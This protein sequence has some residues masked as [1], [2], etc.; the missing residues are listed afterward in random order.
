MKKPR[1]VILTIAIALVAL[2]AWPA[3]A[4]AEGTEL[5]SVSSDETQSDNASAEPSLSADGSCVAFSSTATNLW[6]GDERGEWYD[7]DNPPDGVVDTFQPY[8]QVYVRDLEAGTTQLVSVNGDGSEAGDHSSYMPSVNAD[9][10]MVAFA[11]YSTNLIDGVG[12][13]VY[14]NIFV[15]DL[16]NGITQLVSETHG[17]GPV[18]GECMYPSISADGSA[19]A[20]IS[21]ATNLLEG[22]TNGCS[23]VFVRYLTG[24]LAGTT[25]LASVAWGGGPSEGLD[26]GYGVLGSYDPS[27]DADGSVVAFAS[28]ATNLLAEEDTDESSDV[29]VRDL[30]AGTTQPVSVVGGGVGADSWSASPS[31]NADGSVVAFVS[32]ANEPLSLGVFALGEPVDPVAGPD[33]FVRDLV[34]GTTELVSVPSGGV[35][36]D[37]VNQDPSI[38][39]DGSIVAFWSVYETHDVAGAL[40]FAGTVVPVELPNVFVRDRDRGTTTLLSVGWDGSASNGASFGPSVSADGSLVAFA[41]DATN[42]VFGDA[43]DTWDVFLARYA[44]PKSGY[45]NRYE[46]TDPLILYSG[47]WQTGQNKAHSGGSNYSTDDKTATITITF[48]GTR[49]DWIA[50]LGPLMGKALVSIDGGEPVLVDLFSDT[51]LFQQLVWSTGELEYGVHTITITFPEGADYQEGK[52]INIDALDVW[53]VLLETT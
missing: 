32:G 25:V 45:P 17:G 48:K 44:P 19:V 50:A 46:E 16:V 41:S 22:D 12:S 11:S 47:N 33:V 26:T 13:G 35:G 18:D 49:L 14:T 40:A 43:N 38:N 29:F 15:R 24:P 36:A 39:A 52:G 4:Q 51:E 28:Y 21:W 1:A 23:D 3:L 7:S 5:V 53:G 20:F 6:A 2:L 31:I 10:S 42:L 34:A 27:I 9:G 8:M 37:N 30:V